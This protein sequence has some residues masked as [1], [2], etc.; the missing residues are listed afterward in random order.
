MHLSNRT[1]EPKSHRSFRYLPLK[2]YRTVFSRRQKD[3]MCPQR[4]SAL[5]STNGTYP[6]LQHR[7][8]LDWAVFDWWTC[9]LPAT[10]SAPT[11]HP[12]VDRFTTG[13]ITIQ[14]AK[15]RSLSICCV[16]ATEFI[17]LLQ[18]DQADKGCGN[19][20]VWLNKQC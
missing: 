11:P 12:T 10:A 6:P 8:C 16:S 19:S 17:M 1:K 20:F 13:N 7:P 15:N 4:V 18:S 3:R 2:I 5:F 14:S 9:V